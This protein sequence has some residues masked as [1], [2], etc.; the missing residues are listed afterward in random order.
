MGNVVKTVMENE[1]GEVSRTQTV[2]SLDLTLRGRKPL[3]NVSSDMIWF[4]IIK[5]FL[6]EYINGTTI[7]ERNMKGKKTS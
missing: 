3:K 5:N 1:T 6:L 2:K 4:S 7:R